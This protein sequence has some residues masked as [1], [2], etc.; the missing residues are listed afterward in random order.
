MITRAMVD[1][2]VPEWPAG[3]HGSM[4]MAS[5]LLRHYAKVL[6]RKSYN[7][8]T[9]LAGGILHPGFD[10]ASRNLASWNSL[11]TEEP[12]LGRAKLKELARAELQEADHNLRD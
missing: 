8:A 6:D 7:A 5:A 2:I 9:L 3:K 10:E 11:H 4:L 12:D 1:A